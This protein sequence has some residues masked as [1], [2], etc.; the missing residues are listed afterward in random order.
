[1]KGKKDVYTASLGLVGAAIGLGNLWRFPYM[2]GKNGGGA[3]LIVYISFVVLLGVP[4]MLGEFILGRSS[5]NSIVGAFKRFTPGT[6]WYLAGGLGILTSSLILSFY[7]VVGGWSLK[8]FYLSSTNAFLGKNSQELGDIFNKFISSPVDPIFWQ[9]LFM[10]ITALVL[11]SK[12]EGSMEKI[13][14]IM[15][16]MLFLIIM[17]LCMKALVLPEIGNGMAFFLKPD[18]SKITAGGIQAAMGQAFFSLSIGMGVLITYG[19][20]M[21][22]DE[23]LLISTLHVIGTDTLVA[24]LIGVIVFP[25]AFTYGIE[26]GSGPGLVFTALSSLFN[27]IPGGYG[28]GVMFFLLL[29]LAALTTAISLLE[30]VVTCLTNQCKLSRNT[31]VFTAMVLITILGAVTSLSLGIWRDTNL[32]YILDYVTVD[33][34][35]PIIAMLISLYLGYVLE[36]K[37][38]EEEMANDGVKFKYTKILQNMLKFVCPVIIGSVLLIGLILN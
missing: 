7:G 2:V 29:F 26:P 24:F 19:S 8:F 36:L 1:M 28:L 15:M 11:I 23:N 9:V 14:K 21:K 33:V 5:H 4:L 30:S 22:S 6:P 16:P 13:T 17:V 27:D 25:V 20:F 31:S 34:F 37:V 12:I 18:F 3:F 35:L 10:L 32:F 38:M